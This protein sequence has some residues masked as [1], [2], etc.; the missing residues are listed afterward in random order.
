MVGQENVV[1]EVD[2]MLYGQLADNEDYYLSHFI[3]MIIN[4][5]LI[6]LF[7]THLFQVLDVYEL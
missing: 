4:I 2:Q 3:L 1:T 6:S 5:C 7:E